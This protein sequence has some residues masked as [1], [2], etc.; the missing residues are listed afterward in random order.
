MHV[1]S[2]MSL[3]SRSDEFIALNDWLV[4]CTVSSLVRLLSRKWSFEALSNL[5]WAFTILFH[6]P[7]ST[8]G[9]SVGPKLACNC[10]QYTVWR[11][12]SLPLCKNSLVDREFVTCAHLPRYRPT[13]HNFGAICK[14]ILVPIRRRFLKLQN[15]KFSTAPCDSLRRDRWKITRRHDSTTNQLSIDAIR[16]AEIDVV[17]KLSPL[18]TMVQVKKIRGVC[19]TRSD[20]GGLCCLQA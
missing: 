10:I 2:V 20:K 7:V 14:V 3:S 11:I 16:W 13:A 4:K 18:T 8:S 12:F 5:F 17:H 9:P 19:R 1:R 6:L 15:C